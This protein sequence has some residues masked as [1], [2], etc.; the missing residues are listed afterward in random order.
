[1]LFGSEIH[2][3][4]AQHGKGGEDGNQDRETP[5]GVEKSRWPQG[6]EV[7][8]GRWRELLQP[9]EPV[10]AMCGLGREKSHREKKTD[11]QGEDLRAED[12]LA[13]ALDG[14]VAAAEL[15]APPEQAGRGQI[16]GSNGLGARGLEG[17]GDEDQI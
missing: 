14:G 15:G 16:G 3:N 6:F 9:S 11:G 8:R 7:K 4:A 5:A 1:L 10:K 17:A 13:N 12:G 2:D